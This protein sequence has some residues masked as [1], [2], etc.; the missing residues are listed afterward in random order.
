MVYFNKVK[1]E[2]SRVASK[3][4]GSF[5]LSMMDQITKRLDVLDKR[6]DDL[7]A[8]DT[9]PTLRFDKSSRQMTKDNIVICGDIFVHSRLVV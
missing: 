5:M 2:F 9:S 4:E 7:Y 6:N 3:M 8:D 1:F